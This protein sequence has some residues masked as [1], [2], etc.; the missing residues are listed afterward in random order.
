M[1]IKE[2]RKLSQLRFMVD[3]QPSA[4]TLDMVERVL[5]MNDLRILRVKWKALIKV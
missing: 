4:Q 1:W 5:V 2:R 3:H